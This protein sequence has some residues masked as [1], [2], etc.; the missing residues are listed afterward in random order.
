MGFALGPTAL[1]SELAPPP[2][3]SR[4]TEC[5]R[6]HIVNWLLQEDSQFSLILNDGTDR[7]KNGNATS[8]KVFCF[9]QCYLCRSCSYNSGPQA[10]DSIL[11]N[12]K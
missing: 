3:Q 5:E 12:L 11:Y 2:R 4:C 10:S 6:E 8:K 9:D 1:K 7:D